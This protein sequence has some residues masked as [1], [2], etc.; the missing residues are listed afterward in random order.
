VVYDGNIEI[1]FVPGI[2]GAGAEHWQAIWQREIP[3]A[4]TVEQLDWH[5]PDLRS[6][7]IALE[8]TIERCRN[9]FIL[10]PHSLGCALVA[11]WAQQVSSGLIEAPRAPVLGAMLVAPGDVDR[12]APELEAVR[13]FAPMPQQGFSFPSVVVASTNDPFVSA[14]K[15]ALFA[16]RWGSEL[17]SLGA[18]GHISTED[19]CGLWP[20]GRR[21]LQEFADSRQTALINKAALL[22]AP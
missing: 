18:M 21:I 9:P 16:D 17:I 11:H 10:V 14:E 5:R 19:G 20:Q 7:L 4:H 13:S 6:W 8:R 12:F 15:S 2:G 3:N 1:L 22:K